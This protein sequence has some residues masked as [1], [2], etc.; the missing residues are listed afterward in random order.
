MKISFHLH[1]NGN[2]FLYEKMSTRTCFEKEAKDNSGMAY[3]HLLKFSTT[4]QDTE[5][6]ITF[7]LFI[8][9]TT[10]LDNIN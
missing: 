3:C 9:S 8:G 7:L 4:D 1:V 10:S 5:Y 6:E 2:Q